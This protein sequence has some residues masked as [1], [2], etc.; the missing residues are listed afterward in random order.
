MAQ[1][2]GNQTNLRKMAASFAGMWYSHS[3]RTNPPQHSLNWVPRVSHHAGVLHLHMA[4][5]PGEQRPECSG[6]HP[7]TQHTTR[8]KQ[9]KQEPYCDGRRARAHTHTTWRTKARVQR[10]PQHTAHNTPQTGQTRTLV[11]LTAHRCAAPYNPHNYL[12]HFQALCDPL[13]SAAAPCA[14]PHPSII[15][16]FPCLSKPH[17]S[18]TLHHPHQSSMP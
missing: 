18:F 10:T 4:V 1:G 17:H 6:R 9:G 16:I 15:P 5:C 13:Q 14:L 2:H 7:N 3:S 11:P 8:H 12:Q